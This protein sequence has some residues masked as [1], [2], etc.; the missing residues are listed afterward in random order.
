MFKKNK[1][2]KGNPQMNQQD[3]AP[4]EAILESFV[5]NWQNTGKLS[6]GPFGPGGEITGSTSYGWGV[7]G[8][9]LQ[10]ESHLELPGFG[11]YEVQGG[12]AFNPQ[13]GKYDA[14]AVNSLGN[15][16][17]YKGEW[18][19]ESTLIFILTYPDP[20]GRARVV[21]HILPGGSIQMYSDRKNENGDYETYFKTVMVKGE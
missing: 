10:Y 4:E 11:N 5:G 14:Y 6:P 21:Y 19:N 20:T 13:T 3:I 2:N 7:G 8:K 17:V 12:V 16:M 1:F 15:L 18:E 9:W